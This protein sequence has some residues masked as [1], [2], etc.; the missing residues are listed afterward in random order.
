MLGF[1]KLRDQYLQ[2]LE[3][4]LAGSCDSLLDCGCGERSPIRAFSRAIR[5]SVG[6]E[7]HLP[8]LAS[9]RE[10]GIHTAYV[11]ADVRRVD[12]VFRPRSF[13]AVLASDVIE[14]LEKSEGE[15]LIGSL[16]RLAR[17]LVILFTPN[18]F[19]LQGE[20]DGNP[21]QFHRSGW[22]PEEMQARGYDVIGVHGW[23]PLRGERAR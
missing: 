1:L 13:D 12:R 8:A 19:L 15:R 7:A 16:E 14:H 23:K 22:T 20:A 9:S 3:S 17:K 11:A 5:F 21:F 4:L 2:E 10:R 18:G 6:V